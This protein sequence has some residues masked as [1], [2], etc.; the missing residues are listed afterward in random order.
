MQ[1]TAPQGLTRQHKCFSLAACSVVQDVKAQ[2]TALQGQ[3][4]RLESML[5]EALAAKA[6]K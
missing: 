4:D 2:L 1:L 6:E 5:R 3:V